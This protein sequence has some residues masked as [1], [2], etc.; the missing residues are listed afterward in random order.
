MLIKLHKGSMY[1]QNICGPSTRPCGAL[2]SLINAGGHIHMTCC[3]SKSYD[4]N[5]SKQ[6]I[7]SQLCVEW[8]L[9]SSRTTR[10][11]ASTVNNFKGSQLHSLC[12]AVSFSSKELR[13]YFTV[14][15]T[16]E[17]LQ[18]RTLNIINTVA[19]GFRVSSPQDFLQPFSHYA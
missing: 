15:I 19:E 3:S 13:C 16:E 8:A 14:F 9:R 1:K 10:A 17:E 11:Q 4:T 2:K 12:M 7:L 6:Y 18:Q 5:Q